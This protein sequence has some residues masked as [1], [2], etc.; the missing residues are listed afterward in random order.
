MFQ[1]SDLYMFPYAERQFLKLSCPPHEVVHQLFRLPPDI[2][3]QWLIQHSKSRRSWRRRLGLSSSSSPPATAQTPPLPG[4]GSSPVC[5]FHCLCEIFQLCAHLHL[6]SSS[7]VLLLP[8]SS[9]PVEDAPR[10]SFRSSRRTHKHVIV[11]SNCS[12]PNDDG[13]FCWCLWFLLAFGF[14]GRRRRPL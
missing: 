8:A 6:P 10:V 4:P 13:C 5:P 3:L 11:L 7:G 9:L 12:L 2:T 14:A 1:F